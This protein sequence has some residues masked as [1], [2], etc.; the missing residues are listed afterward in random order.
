MR[1]SRKTVVVVEDAGACATTLEIALGQIKQLEICVV[2]SA[3]AARAF[4]DS[5]VEVTAV[6]TDLNLPEASGLDLIEWLRSRDGSGRMPIIVISGE[7]DPDLPAKS[8]LL[9][10]NAYFSKPFSPA[11]VRRRLED[12]IDAEEESWPEPPAGAH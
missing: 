8:L 3:E 4:I 2:T 9:G 7:S 10:A 12:L 1:G 11:Q 5:G 6:V